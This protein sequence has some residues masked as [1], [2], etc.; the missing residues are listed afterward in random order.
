M[1]KNSKFIWIKISFFAAAF[2]LLSGCA[3]DQ[4]RLEKEE[5]Y[6]TIG[7]RA[8]EDGNYEE[9]MEAFNNALGQTKK[10]GALEMDICYYKAAAQFASGNLTDAV[11]TYDALLESDSK[12]S[13]A[14]FLRGCVYLN[15]NEVAKAKEDFEKAIEYAQ[16]DEIYLAVNNS[17]V[18]AG[19]EAEGKAYI[20]EA[21]EKKA[22]RVAQ[23]YTVK[24]KIY[25]LQEDYKN[26]E[27]ALLTAV[28]KGDVEANLTLAQTYEAMGE[29]QKAESCIDAYIKVNPESSVAYNQLG[30]S[31]MQEKNYKEA[32]SYFL[33]G[34]ELDN[35]TNE[36]EL[37]SNLI[38]AY[39]YNGEFEKAAEQMETYT[40]DY[41]KDAAAAKEYLFLSRNKGEE[42][43]KK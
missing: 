29:E 6:R 1:K 34:L 16:T 30:C 12:N 27:E 37:R 8:M 31:E 2:C 28:E 23:N 11:E 24:G 32:V 36:Q 9:A 38:A 4:E 40:K 13:D 18:G 7:I 35:V 14:Y 20:E 3:S 21:L 15:M 17:L 42:K 19:Y 22:G 5:A 43:E 33:K 41:P 25:Y 26:A 10:L 39:E